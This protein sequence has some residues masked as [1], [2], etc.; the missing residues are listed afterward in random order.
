MYTLRTEKNGS[1]AGG[2]GQ[3]VCWM[4][5]RHAEEIW[6]QMM[7]M[8]IVRKYLGENIAVQRQILNIY[9]SCDAILVSEEMFPVKVS[10][11]K[12]HLSCFS[13][14]MIIK[15]ISWTMFCKSI[16][17]RSQNCIPRSDVDVH[18]R[19][20]VHIQWAEPRHEPIFSDGDRAP[21]PA[22]M[23]DKSNTCFRIWN[24]VG[25]LESN[26]TV[27]QAWALQ[28]LFWQPFRILSCGR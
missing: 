10:E 16:E 12:D 15:I 18:F 20:C 14:V 26:M 27:L 7:N 23:P 19:L 4:N 1:V 2:K 17:R 9:L 28:N 8:G 5:T 22:L 13:C 21:S 11:W 3:E 6:D 24:V 25:V